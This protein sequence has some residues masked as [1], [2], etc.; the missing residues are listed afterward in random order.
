MKIC[1]CTVPLR[2]EPSKDVPLGAMAIVEAMGLAGHQAH[3]YD[4]DYLRPTQDQMLAY[5]L[6]QQYDLVGVSAVVSTTY[7][8]VK[9][10]VGLIKTHLPQTVVV[11]GGN[12]AS[13]AELLLLKC[14]VDYCI[15]GEGERP[16]QELAQ[17]L[18]SGQAGPE[19]LAEIQGLCY[20][21][22]N[23]EFRFSSYAKQ[24]RPKEMYWPDYDLLEGQGTRSFYIYPPQLAS[25][26]AGLVGGDDVA[27]RFATLPIAKGCVNRCTFCH[28]WLKGYRARPVDQIVEHARMLKEKYG[29][30][31]VYLSDEAFGSAP[32]QSWELAEKLGELGLNW[33]AGGVR[34]DAVDLEILQHWH[35]NGCF[36]VV[37]GTET[38]SQ[39]MLDV[40]EKNTTL[41]DNVDSYRWA[42]QAGISVGALAFV[43]GMP[44]EDNA[45][46][47]QSI[48]FV[49]Q[50]LPFVDMAPGQ[51]PS[52]RLSLNWALALP[53]CPLYEF[54]RQQ[55]LLGQG[56]EGEEAY[57]LRISNQEA[58]SLDHYL[59]YDSL[60]QLMLLIW[61]PWLL[62]TADADFVQKNHGVKY[63]VWGVI[64]HLAGVYT[65]WQWA[66][67]ADPTPGEQ[68]PHKF[69]P[70]F[71]NPLTRWLFYPLLACLVAWDA[72]TKA[73]SRRHTLAL[74]AKHL[75]FSLR[76][77]LRK[78][79]PAS[80]GSLR[81]SLQILEPAGGGDASDDALLLRLG[82]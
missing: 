39:K 30:G 65:D 28:R 10:L 49:K 48:E 76:G 59:N 15:A 4:L 69:A 45:T 66:R 1:I 27:G 52:R 11:V 17:V 68:R 73:R 57:L 21:D 3:L 34:A 24:L 29:V 79:S 51:M 19:R 16:L 18:E 44:G 6:E 50:V 74:V 64:R 9:Q 2:G 71:I 63:S 8:Y 35:K 32:R 58:Y 61:Q 41:K 12:L 60:P 14:Q 72:G 31:S 80:T 56:L 13:S 47:A 62:A 22:Q 42:Q 78:A 37:F 33:F 53:G 70:I 20:L 67:P 75:V 46:I 5:F 40:M 54:A 26:R 36:E 38:G 25:Y 81:K 7:K 43:L 23:G 82:R 77:R 55:G